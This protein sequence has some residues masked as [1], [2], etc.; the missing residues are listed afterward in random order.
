MTKCQH[1]LKFWKYTKCCMILSQSFNFIL[2][3]LKPFLPPFPS[4]WVPLSWE[5]VVRQVV[6]NSLQPH[7][8]QHVRLPCPSLYPRVCPNSCP[9][10]QSVMLSNYL[11]FCCLLLLLPSAFLSIRTFS[12]ESALCI[13]WTK[14]WSFSIS[15]FSEF[16]GLISFR[17][18]CF[19]LRAVQGVS[20]VFSITTVQKHQ[21]F[22]PAFRS[23][24]GLLEKP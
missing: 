13:R 23:V 6:S 3:P 4:V 17:I 24:Q 7:E 5:A 21:F 11:I 14:Y 8:L 20:R 19:D 15:P 10:N 1:V 16:S 2:T 12:N 22:G 9:W 18:D